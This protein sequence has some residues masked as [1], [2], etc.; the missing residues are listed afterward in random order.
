MNLSPK[1]QILIIAGPTAT[2][3]TE[4]SLELA[5][6]LNGEII[7]IDS[8]QIYRHFNIGSAK[9]PVAE[10]QGIPHHLIDIL[11]PNQEFNVAMYKNLADALVTDLISRGKTPIFV[12]GSNLYI[13]VLLHGLS[14][15]MQSDT[16][17]RD[18][19]EREELDTLV[20]ELR[21]LDPQV[22]K[23]ID[24]QNKRR[25]VRALESLR[26]SRYSVS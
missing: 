12:G 8:V 4:L 18:S 21:A 7:N 25:V 15:E 9:L 26:L 5:K 16:K 14:P 13:K 1:P 20:C 10:Q 17:L 22:S 19:L 23:S 2:G 11:D 3:K 24:L 6:R